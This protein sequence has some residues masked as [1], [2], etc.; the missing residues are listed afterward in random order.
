MIRRAVISVGIVVL[1]ALPAI[2]RQPASPTPP[3]GPASGNPLEVGHPFIRV[4][5]P[6]EIGGGTQTWSMVQDR[7]GVM[8]FSTN[9]AILEFDGASWRRIQVGTNAASVRALALDDA[10]RIWVGA[11][12]NFGY[13]APDARGILSYVS[14]ADRLPPGAPP[15]ADV[16]RVFVTPD[17]TVFQTTRA[18]FI[19]AHEK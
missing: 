4:Y 14:M 8:Y 11:V 1:C 17:G 19:W 3:A 5:Q 16:W 12:G 6:L 13:L 7:R 18:I 2:A 9:S 10:G 15:F